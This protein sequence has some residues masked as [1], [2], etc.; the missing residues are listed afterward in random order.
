MGVL[1]LYLGSAFVGAVVGAKVLDKKKDYKVL[2][3]LSTICLCIIIFVMGARI[4]SDDKVIESL[5][6]IGIKAFVITMLCFI[7]SVGAVFLIR[8]AIGIDNRG[9]AKFDS[10]GETK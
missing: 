1:A 3:R 7:G 9:E 6:T 10:K 4:G 2:N 5:Q 8:R